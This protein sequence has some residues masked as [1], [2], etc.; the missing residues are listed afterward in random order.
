[1]LADGLTIILAGLLASTGIYDLFFDI[2]WADFFY[3]HF[4]NMHH[5]IVD[6]SLTM[7]I[8]EVVLLSNDKHPSLHLSRRIGIKKPP[9]VKPP[10]VI[11]FNLFL[12]SLVW[13]IRLYGS[14]YSLKGLLS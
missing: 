11:N 13:V 7:C 12:K 2:E 5:G 10:R 6:F 14:F 1:M 9:V 3:I 8:L 4:E